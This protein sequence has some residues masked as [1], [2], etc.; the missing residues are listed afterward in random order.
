M[1]PFCACRNRAVRSN[2]SAVR[3][4]LSASISTCRKAP[5]STR[6]ASPPVAT[7][8]STVRCAHVPQSVGR[9]TDRHHARL[10]DLRRRTRRREVP[11]LPVL[12]ARRRTGIL[13]RRPLAG[14]AGKRVH[15]PLR[16]P[17]RRRRVR[18]RARDQG[19]AGC[20]RPRRPICVGQDDH[21]S[22]R[23]AHTSSGNTVY[24]SR[25]PTTCPRGGLRWKLEATF[26]ENGE[27]SK[28]E[29]ARSTYTTPCPAASVEA[30]V[31]ETSVPGTG[32]IVTA[33]SNKVC[34]SRRDFPIHVQL[35]RRDCFC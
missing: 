9:R 23:P 17:R 31:P 32:G 4:R 14:V 22:G 34:L 18:P 26:A 15:R 35:S 10:R 8:H 16:Q 20:G 3:L 1:P 33:P 25:V 30:P 7:R 21:R 28:S 5:S 24:Y 12:L 27:E 19:A 2:T 11:T 29:T 6:P 13:H